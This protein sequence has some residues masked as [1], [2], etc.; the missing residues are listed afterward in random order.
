MKRFHLGL[1][2]L[3]LGG[4]G[5]AAIIYSADFSTEGEGFPDHTSSA[6]PAAAPASAS[7]GT[8]GPPEG[9]WTV[10]YADT[11]ATDGTT[12]EFS[13]NSGVLRVQDWGGAA[14]FVSEPVT[15]PG[16]GSVTFSGSATT[17]SSGAFD[18][19]SEGFEWFY[20][21]NGG[22]PIAFGGVGQEFGGNDVGGDI[23]ISASAADIPVN[24][25]D[26]LTF[27]FNF[28]VNGQDDGFSVSSMT[29]DYIPE[30]GTALGSSV[31][32]L[33]L[34]RRRREPSGLAHT[35]DL[36]HATS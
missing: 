16:T 1:T 19:G 12:N 29:I 22:G 21:I 15:A 5:H 7:G 6:P 24:G 25:G 14:S 17:L 34:L 9:R 33:A 20:T 32:L 28:D 26:T 36:T 30:P 27:G 10:S 3:L 35:Q 8:A 4:I 11:P 31:I 18:S 2:S 13:V 23:D